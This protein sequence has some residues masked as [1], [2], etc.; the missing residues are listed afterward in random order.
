MD[1]EKC[2]EEIANNGKVEDMEELSE[3]LEGSMKHLKDCNEEMYKKYEMKLYEMA[4]GKRL[5]D[6]IKTKWVKSMRPTAKWNFEEIEQ[7]YSRYDIDV[8]MYSFYV[9]INLLYSDMQ[10]ALGAEDDEK[11]LTK[12]IQ[13]TVDWYYDEDAINT[14]EAKLY[15]Y[16]K[17]IVN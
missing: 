13:A 3:I 9:I 12:Y 16:W 14:E 2:I 11:T 1:I 6:E 15:A 5:T 8:P 10:R 4:Y 17:H 7:I